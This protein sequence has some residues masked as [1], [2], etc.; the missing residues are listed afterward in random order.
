MVKVPVGVSRLNWIQ[1][2]QLTSPTPGLMTGASPILILD[3]APNVFILMLGLGKWFNG[4]KF[5]ETTSAKRNSDQPPK[6]K[7]P[8]C[9]FC[10][11]LIAF[12]LDHCEE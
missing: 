4:F 12:C 10:K 5:C 1:G 2:F 3:F 7:S 8:D 11:K 6:S 9:E